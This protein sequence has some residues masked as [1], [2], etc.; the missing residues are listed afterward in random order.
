MKSRL[1]TPPPAS[2]P[3]APYDPL[4]QAFL[5]WPP[6]VWQWREW[7][8][9]SP[10]GLDLVAK[11]SDP[12]KYIAVLGVDTWRS[13]VLELLRTAAYEDC[14]AAGF[15]F[16]EDRLSGLWNTE[17][18]AV[19]FVL[20]RARTHRAVIWTE[21][22]EQAGRLYVDGKPV[23]FAGEAPAEHTAFTG[24]WADD[25][26]FNVPVPGPEEHPAQAYGIG[27]GP[28]GRVQGLLIHDAD[29][30][31]HH[32]LQ[33]TANQR[34]TDPWLE[35]RDGRWRVHADRSRGSHASGTADLV[36]ELPPLP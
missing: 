14:V 7:L 12:T 24:H 32:V 30:G 6:A 13:S 5:R 28:M 31:V 8:R 11:L 26:F 21:N 16:D 35:V 9:R 19:A 25:R 34:W 10:L 33:P 29:T 17:E 1:Q 2:A 20:N 4:E 3:A 15:D 27:G 18:R 36:L 23:R 22:A